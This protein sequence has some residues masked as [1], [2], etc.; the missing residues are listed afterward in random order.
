MIPGRVRSAV[1]RLHRYL[2]QTIEQ[3]QVFNARGQY[4]YTSLNGTAP[5][6]LMMQWDTPRSVGGG[7]A[8][9]RSPGLLTQLCVCLPDFP[10]GSSPLMCAIMYRASPYN[11]PAGGQPNRTYKYNAHE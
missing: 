10:K 6:I 3:I 1:K 5:G 4:S 9:T 8:E 7:G 2:L 11:E